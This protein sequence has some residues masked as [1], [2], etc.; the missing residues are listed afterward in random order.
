M[1]F[2]KIGKGPSQSPTAQLRQTQAP[3]PNAGNVG[4]TPGARE[5][6][7]A[8][9]TTAPKSPLGLHTDQ[10]DTKKPTPRDGA[11]KRVLQSPEDAKALHSRRG[12]LW[13]PVASTHPQTNSPADGS[14]PIHATDLQGVNSHPE[15]AIRAWAEKCTNA[16]Q[17][18]AVIGNVLQGELTKHET[19]PEARMGICGALVQGWIGMLALGVMSGEK[20]G[21]AKTSEAFHEHVR[22]SLE[23]LKAT[24][25]SLLSENRANGLEEDALDVAFD[26]YNTLETSGTESKTKL[27]ALKDSLLKREATHNTKITAYEDN[28]GA[29]LV[30]EDLV[31]PEDKMPTNRADLVKVLG[32]CFKDDAAY[33]IVICQ[34]NASAGHVIG[35]FKSGDE[36]RMMDPNTAEWKAKSPEQLVSVL[37]DHLEELYHS[38]STR[39]DRFTSLAVVR[40]TLPKPETYPSTKQP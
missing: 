28:L 12:N 14:P 35:V 10:V 15:L 26:D 24:N 21:V 11:M 33:R 4:T 20:Q 6:T 37:A 5:G 40:H 38:S 13:K 3:T 1:T 39:S 8:P 16:N 32:E 17:D 31:V 36:Y 7:P 29:G 25:H 27:D 30:S 9:S 23:E 22:S 19:D 18:S 2:N 34:D